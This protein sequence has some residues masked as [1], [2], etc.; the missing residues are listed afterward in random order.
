VGKVALITFVVLAFSLWLVVPPVVLYNFYME[1]IYPV[2]LAKEYLY[3]AMSVN[4]VEVVKKYLVMASE[5]LQPYSGYVGLW[6]DPNVSFDV[7][8]ERLKTEIMACEKFADVPQESYEY[9]RFM[10]EIKDELSVIVKALESTGGLMWLCSTGHFPTNLV[11]GILYSIVAGIAPFIAYNKI[12]DW[13]WKKTRE[14]IKE[15]MG[16]Y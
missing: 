11:L 8:K 10:E 12:K 1:V 9:Q 2:D 6:F 15:T 14:E 5:R 3:A 13:E 7:I 16:I 4:D